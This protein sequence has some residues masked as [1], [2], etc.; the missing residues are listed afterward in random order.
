MTR[1]EW[2]IGALFLTIGVAVGFGVG[3]AQAN[4]RWSESRRL[5]NDY[6]RSGETDRISCALTAVSVDHPIDQRWMDA[7]WTPPKASTR[8][9]FAPG[10]Q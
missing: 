4:H 8:R 3:T 10:C 2:L 6:M 9:N 7:A 5:I 1:V